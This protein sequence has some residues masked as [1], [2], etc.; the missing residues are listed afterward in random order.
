M[1]RYRHVQ[2]VERSPSAI[3]NAEDSP[4]IEYLGSPDHCD[5]CGRP[6]KDEHFFADALLPAHHNAAGILCWTCT[7]VEGIRPS[8]GRAQFYR[9]V[10]EEMT[11]ASQNPGRWLCVAGGP[12]AEVIDAENDAE[13]N[14]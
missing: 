14:K 1:D 8:W 7:Q 2:S 3:Q 11:P 12:S 9:W 6:M 10:A 4:A 13:A 5:C